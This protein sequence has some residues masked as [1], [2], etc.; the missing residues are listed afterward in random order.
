MM[1]HALLAATLLAAPA[2]A[3]VQTLSFDDISG[4][5]LVTQYLNPF[6]AQ[7]TTYGGLTWGPLWA[8]VDA[9]GECSGY[10]CGFKTGKTSGNY[11]ATNG[12]N[13]TGTITSATPFRM[14]SVQLGSAWYDPLD[15]AIVG[16]LGG[17]TV[18]STSFVASAT[19][20]TLATFPS[21]L[22]DTLEV[23]PTLRPNSSWIF[24]IGSGPRMVWDDFSFDAS[25]VVGG[26]P[27]PAAWAMLLAG[28]GLVGG[29]ARRQR[30]VAS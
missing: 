12:F 8:T 22:V 11:V 4:T 1:K 30:V 17:A 29:I 19:G 24:P 18:W 5:P 3:A 9:A 16:K 10:N 6:V 23:T 25:P 20:P 2:S 7:F 27:E 28:F 13:G 14:M 26:V 21:G 15:I